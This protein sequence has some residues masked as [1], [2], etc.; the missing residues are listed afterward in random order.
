MS[1]AG[2]RLEFDPRNQLIS[3][4]VDVIKRV[5]PKFVFMENVPKQL[6]TKIRYGKEII[7]IP[8]YIKGN[9]EKITLLIIK[10]L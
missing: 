8:E 5:K 7:L 4:A 1:E 6:T 2:L 3:Y 10:R 9:L